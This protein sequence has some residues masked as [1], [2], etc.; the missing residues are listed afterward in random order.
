MYLN[1]T[2]N[3]EKILSAFDKLDKLPKSI[4]KIGSIIALN[5]LALGSLLLIF[6]HTVLIYDQ[7]FELIARSVIKNSVTL[8]AEAFIGGLIMDYVFKRN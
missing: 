8:L 5:L 7:K 6:N 2:K 4:I 1:I 3:L